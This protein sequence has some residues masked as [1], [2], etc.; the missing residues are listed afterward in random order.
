[1]AMWDVSCTDVH[2]AAIQRPKIPLLACR[3]LWAHSHASP[4]AWPM[5]QTRCRRVTGA[6]HLASL[7]P[8]FPLALSSAPW[9][10]RSYRRWGQPGLLSA[11]L[12]ST[13]CT[14]HCYC[15]SRCPPNP[16][17]WCASSLFTPTRLVCLTQFRSLCG[18][19][20]HAAALGEAQWA[21]ILRSFTDATSADAGVPSTRAHTYV[22]QTSGPSGW[23]APQDTPDVGYT[24]ESRLHGLLL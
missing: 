24:N 2:L 20:P 17:S 3:Q 19:L 4:Y 16:G 7:W 13:A 10:A 15:Q 12:P 5:W 9:Q 21:C 11:G 6:P 1:M 22:R 18:F 14:P 23:Q 8:R